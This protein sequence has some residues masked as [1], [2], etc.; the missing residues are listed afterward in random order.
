M[1]RF[2]LGG[3]AY[4]AKEVLSDDFPWSCT[5]CSFRGK[6][7]CMATS[8]VPDCAHASKGK[9]IIWVEEVE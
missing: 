4:V 7:C 2:E 8:D 6:S 3:K 5:G 1:D 9:T